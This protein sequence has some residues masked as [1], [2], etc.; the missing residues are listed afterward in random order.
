M[1]LIIKVIRRIKLK[2]I[3]IARTILIKVIT[4]T[5][6]KVTITRTALKVIIIITRTTLKVI[7]RTRPKVIRRIQLKVIGRIGPLV[8]GRIG[9]IGP[10][11]ER[12][13][14][15]GPLTKVGGQSVSQQPGTRL[16]P[17]L[18]PGEYTPHI[19]PGTPGERIQSNTQLR[20]S[21]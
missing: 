2:V 1:R 6:L 15:I 5:T 7:I 3:L 17:G 20:N 4:R 18:S 16:S 10:L 21:L 11:A 19:C 13:G 9:P 8:I 12:I 14:P